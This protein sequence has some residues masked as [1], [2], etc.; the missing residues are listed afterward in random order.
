DYIAGRLE[1][2]ENVTLTSLQHRFSA[3]NERDD[4]MVPTLDYQSTLEEAATVSGGVTRLFL[5]QCL[6]ANVAVRSFQGNK[7]MPHFR[8][9]QRGIDF[10]HIDDQTRK[11][12]AG[13][14]VIMSTRP[15]P[16]CITPGNLIEAIYD[17]G[18]RPG[19]AK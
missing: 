11:F 9:L 5:S 17:D 14:A 16:P 18:K 13:S 12:G 3:D 10:A 1:L 6:G 7:A 8:F 19:L 4:F 15:N 2:D